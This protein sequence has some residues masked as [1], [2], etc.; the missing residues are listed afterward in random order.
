VNHRD[1]R[2][3]SVEFGTGL[4]SEFHGGLADAF[5]LAL[6]RVGKYMA[7]PFGQLLLASLLFDGVGVG[8]VQHL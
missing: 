5:C 1:T 6:Q 2:S 8:M 4:E 7:I 3:A